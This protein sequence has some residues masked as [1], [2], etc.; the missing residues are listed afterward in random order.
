LR[1]EKNPSLESIR[2]CRTLPQT[3]AKDC[4]R[5]RFCKDIRGAQRDTWAFEEG[6]LVIGIHPSFVDL[7]QQLIQEDE[8]ELR[9]G[10]V[11]VI[12][13]MFADKWALC[14]RL[15]MSDTIMPV[16]HSD[17]V[18]YG[19]ENIKFLPLCAVTLAANFASFDRRWSEY[20]MLCPYS[21]SFPSGGLRVTPPIRCDSVLA[22]V[23][24]AACN[25]ASLHVPWLVFHLCKPRIPL[26]PK[27]EH[28]PS[29]PPKRGIGRLI[30]NT[31]NGRNTLGRMWRTI[32]PCEASESQGSS[33]NHELYL[34]KEVDF[35]E[36]DISSVYQDEPEP[37]QE[38]PSKDFNLRSPMK[39]RKSI[40]QLFFGSRR[41]KQLEVPDEKAQHE[42]KNTK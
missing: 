40:R 31:V 21:N 37:V 27:T 19:F 36:D 13:R 30:D 16:R 14:A 35:L 8:F 6:S 9:Y 41:Y 38:E 17:L 15:R 39:K 2:P 23:E 34:D 26:P 3:P 18:D 4:Q 42:E 1:E 25:F 7:N 10:E 29:H 24:I 11:Y 12:C 33:D 22:S 32:V 20:R 28:V 5:L